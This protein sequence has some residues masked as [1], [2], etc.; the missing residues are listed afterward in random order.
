MKT[1]FEVRKRNK[2]KKKKNLGTKNR[3]KNLHKHKH[4]GPPFQI[5]PGPG[6]FRLRHE[7]ATYLY[8]SRLMIQAQVVALV[9]C[10]S[11]LFS[12]TVQSHSFK[13]TFK[14]QFQVVSVSIQAT[15]VTF[16]SQSSKLL[17]HFNLL[18]YVT[19]LSVH[20]KKLS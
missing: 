3:R 12:I 15:E 14:S 7:D 6:C 13:S 16:S 19:S 2:F 20:F 17:H 5:R 8:C 1:F 11:S 9:Y 18:L 10:F 4:S